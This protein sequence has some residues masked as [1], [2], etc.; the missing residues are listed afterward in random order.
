MLI[1]RGV[2]MFP[3]QIEDILLQHTMLSGQ[4]QIQV[5]REGLLDQVEVRC[6]VRP[7]LVG[8]VEPERRNEIA[9]WLQHRIK[10][11]VGISTRVSVLEPDMIERTLTGKAR[12]VIDMRSR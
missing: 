8:Q 3:T 6:E 12:R 4:Y 5:S 1:I 7:P 9:K 10:T 2:N 11:M